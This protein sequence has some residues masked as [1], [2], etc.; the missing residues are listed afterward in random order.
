MKRPLNSKIQSGKKS[1]T[2][3]SASAKV[4]E[5]TKAKPKLVLKQPLPQTNFE[6]VMVYHTRNM[7]NICR[8]HDW[9]DHEISNL[10]AADIEVQIKMSKPSTK[11]LR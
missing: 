4:V 11:M 5:A 10:T 7:E 8:G 2:S 6:S 1:K 9:N 3:A